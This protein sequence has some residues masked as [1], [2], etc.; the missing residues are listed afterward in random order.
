M[1][2][3]LTFFE[4]AEVPAYRWVQQ[5]PK[6]GCDGCDN[7]S[8]RTGIRCSRIPCQR[9]PGYVVRWTDNTVR[10]FA[11]SERIRLDWLAAAVP[12]DFMRMYRGGET[13]RLIA[14]QRVPY[15]T[16]TAEVA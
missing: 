10:A 7:L 14:V 8:A 15:F 11:P 9:M 1:T 5:G 16:N 4:P 12:G 3:P 13:P 6:G 2:G